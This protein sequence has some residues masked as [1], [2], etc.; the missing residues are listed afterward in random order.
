VRRRILGRNF[1]Q[2]VVRTYEISGHSGSSRKNMVQLQGTRSMVRVGGHSRAIEVGEPLAGL[3]RL[4][5]P[6]ARS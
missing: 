6:F 3:E 1:N 5:E 4:T 2:Q